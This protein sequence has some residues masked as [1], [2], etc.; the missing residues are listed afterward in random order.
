MGQLI[1]HDGFSGIDPAIVAGVGRSPSG[2]RKEMQGRR[3]RALHQGLKHPGIR[4][5]WMCL[6]A[7]RESGSGSMDGEP[8]SA[9]RRMRPEGEDRRLKAT[10]GLVRR[11]S[12]NG[13]RA[14]EGMSQRV[15]VGLKPVA[16]DV[17]V[18]RVGERR[19]VDLAPPSSGRNPW[20]AWNPRRW[21]Q[22]SD[23]RPS[24]G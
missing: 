13:D 7:R 2:R 21:P 8:C 4:L 17:D 15:A 6:L 23:V 10:A 9:C 20:R 1:G 12:L 11:R 16:V 14:E 24:R 18:E 5:R 19:R 3:S 22:Q